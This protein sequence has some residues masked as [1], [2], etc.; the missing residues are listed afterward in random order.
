[1]AI[2]LP[3]QQLRM[4]IEMECRGYALYSRAM[5]LTQDA[6]LLALLDDLRREEALHY[7]TFCA[8]QKEADPA[9]EHAQLAI[10]MAAEAFYPGG[11]MQVSAVG[12]LVSR[13]AMLETAIR[14]ERD[15]VAYYSKMLDG[16]TGESAEA[17][18]SIIA[19]E[20]KHLVTLQEWKEKET[21]R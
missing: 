10:G 13:A 15:S 18:R 2:L 5:Q 4:A 16:L 3:A 21:N 7:E 6:A 11:L 14:A 17:V 19:E 9:G 20:E 8:M 1:M 12:G